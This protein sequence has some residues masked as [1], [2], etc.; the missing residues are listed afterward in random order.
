MLNKALAEM[1]GTFFISFFGIGRIFLSERY[2][3][4]FPAFWIPIVWGLI[5]SLMIFLIGHVSGAHFNPAVTLAFV[6]D[7]RLPMAQAPIY[8]ASQMIG[9]LAAIGLLEILKKT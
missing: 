2:P 9:G 6:I 8:W 3:Q 1:F 5:I 7:K 4:N